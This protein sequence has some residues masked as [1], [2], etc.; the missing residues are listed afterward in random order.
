MDTKELEIS[1]ASS[2]TQEEV[3]IT[4][5][6][7]SP[8][9]ASTVVAAA[10]EDARKAFETGDINLSIVAHNSKANIGAVEKHGGLGSD[11]IK[12][13]VFGGLDGIITTFSICAAIFGAGLGVEVIILTGVANLLSDGISMGLGDAISGKAEH[14][15]IKNERKRE[16]W[17][18]EH[19]REAEIEEMI[20]LYKAKGVKEEDARSILEK[21]SHYPDFFVD[22]M[23]VLEL[24]HMTPS[25]D[26]SPIKDGVVTFISFIIFGG[27]PVLIY[28]IAWGAKYNDPNGIFGIA[29]AATALTLFLLGFVQ[30]KITRLNAFKSGLLMMINGS[31]A[32]ASA[33]L[34]G[35]GLE[36]AMGTGQQCPSPPATPSP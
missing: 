26:D 7:N 34:I 25:P 16:Q 11:Q 10:V 22:H 1:S 27:I 20:D 13:I 30:G 35:W 33:F 15:F 5:T 9:E 14:T 28:V 23:M 2:T 12:S 19:C 3:P 32:A 17:E 4:P 6:A 29:C 31:I 24:E 36:E 18:F 8:K 21:M